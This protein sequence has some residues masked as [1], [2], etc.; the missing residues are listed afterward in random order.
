MGI[1]GFCKWVLKDFVNRYSR[2]WENG[3]S[4]ILYMGIQ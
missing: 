3:Y 1:E 2:I 4:R